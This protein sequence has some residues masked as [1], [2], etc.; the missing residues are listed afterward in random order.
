MSHPSR[1]E[2]RFNDTYIPV[3]LSTPAIID[4]GDFDP[5]LDISRGNLFHSNQDIPHSPPP[6]ITIESCLPPHPSHPG[7]PSGYLPSSYDP[8]PPDEPKSNHDFLPIPESH[9]RHPDWSWQRLRRRSTGQDDHER[10]DI[11][12]P[13]LGTNSTPSSRRQSP[14]MPSI[15]PVSQPTGTYSFEC[16]HLGPNTSSSTV[17]GSFMAP[18]FADPRLLM[19]SRFP[20]HAS[21]QQAEGHMRNPTHLISL[22]QTPP[23]CAPS[24]IGYHHILPTGP[25]SEAGLGLHPAPYYND[26]W[27]P[28]ST[29]V[30]QDSLSEEQRHPL[31]HPSHISPADPIIRPTVTT[32]ATRN[33]SNA[34]IR[35]SARYHCDICGER[36]TTSGNLRST[37]KGSFRE[38]EL[39]TRRL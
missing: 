10:P 21:P 28:P 39:K 12:N 4:S 34:R 3:F 26:D 8:L 11:R 23:F 17:A 16:L 2:A 24:T 14:R 33:A 5:P 30:E 13:Y 7:S 25:S 29:Q 36:F 37:F 27:H 35:N 9:P 1:L 19:P 20:T 15:H 6:P 31:A 22:V 38:I 18:V 32:R